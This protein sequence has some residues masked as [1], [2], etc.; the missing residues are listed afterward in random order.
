MIVKV[1]PF[2]ES[3][4]EDSMDWYALQQPTL[5]LKFL[6]EVEKAIKKISHNPYAYAIKYKRKGVSVRFSIV[7]IFPFVIVFFIDEEKD[8]IVIEAIWHTSRNPKRWK[9]RF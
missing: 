7:D 6:E 3:D 8:L 5:E 9:E 4:L 2:A 1:N